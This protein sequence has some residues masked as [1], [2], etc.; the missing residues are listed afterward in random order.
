MPA[1][2]KTIAS[3]HWAYTTNNKEFI[4]EKQGSMGPSTSSPDCQQVQSCAVP[5]RAKAVAVNL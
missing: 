2:L 3:S 1:H 4:R 5:V